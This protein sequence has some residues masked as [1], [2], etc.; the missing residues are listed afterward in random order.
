MAD[1]QAPE[2]TEQQQLDSILE[3]AVPEGPPELVGGQPAA[4]PPPEPREDER[5]TKALDMIASLQKEVADFK[6]QPAR[7]EVV[8]QQPPQPGEAP[9]E[10][11]EVLP[12]RKIPKD[13]DRRAIKLRPDDLIRMGWN[14]DPAMAINTLANAF[15]HHI[16]EVV[17]AITLAYIQE[18]NN[19]STAG[20]N[21]QQGFYTDFPDLKDFGDLANLVE[22]QA[23]NE[24]DIRGMSQRDWNREVGNRVRQR[25]AAMRGITVDQ[26]NATVGARPSAPSRSRAVTAPPARGGRV[27]PAGGDQQR[28]M[29]DLIEG[30]I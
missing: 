8:Y 9:M 2:Q 15:F 24:V 6:G 26:Y 20:Q 30:R 22:Q 13:L 5:L 12:G 14:E 10:M 1:E 18:Q 25:I 16:A 4:P 3:P 28:E 19:V 21:R 11:I 27:A 7:R 23:L 17:P 29:D